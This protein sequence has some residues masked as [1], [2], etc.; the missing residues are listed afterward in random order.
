[1]SV[2]YAFYRIDNDECI[3]VGSAKNYWMRF[4]NHIWH[5]YATT[6]SLLYKELRNLGGFDK[7]YH[8]IVYETKN[9]NENIKI[10]EKEYYTLLKPLWN[11]YRPL[12]T[13]EERHKDQLR[14]QKKSDSRKKTI[15]CP[16][17]GKFKKNQKK[18]HCLTNI[19]LNYEKKS[20]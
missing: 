12:T 10:K 2:V 4:R 5:Y 8:K 20:K 9:D 18:Q 13:I 16:C 15:D 6:G 14:N 1:M 19:H 11:M 17:G 3:Y 7:I